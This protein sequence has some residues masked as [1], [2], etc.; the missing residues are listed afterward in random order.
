MI[1]WQGCGE[2]LRVVIGGEITE[3]RLELGDGTVAANGGINGN[4]SEED[5]DGI[6]DLFGEVCTGIDADGCVSGDCGA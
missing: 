2:L 5:I 4:F 3:G 6:G 1:V